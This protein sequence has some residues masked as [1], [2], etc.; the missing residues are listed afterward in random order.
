MVC[1]SE[2]PKGCWLGDLTRARSI[3]A[4]VVSIFFHLDENGGCSTSR[5]ILLPSRSDV[6]E[7]IR[8][9]EAVEEVIVEDE[10][11]LTIL[12]RH[13]CPLA[14]VFAATTHPAPPFTVQ[15]GRAEWDHT[16]NGEELR[17]MLRD[18]GLR[19][20]VRRVRKGRGLTPRQREILLRAIE[21]GYY[22][23][24]RRITLSELAEKLG[25]SKSY[26]SET[27]AKVE[28]KLLPEMLI[29]HG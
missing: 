28:S 19:I 14:D 2:L 23:F 6:L 18:R 12:V 1:S 4:R 17:R 27:L 9:H 25:I 21:E 22:D 13:H 24:P 20:A 29:L 16:G 11:P 7:L 10:R 3:R 5:V 8:S 15:A 26:L